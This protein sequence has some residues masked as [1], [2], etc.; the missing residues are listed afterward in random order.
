M[1]EEHAKNYLYRICGCKPDYLFAEKVVEIIK[2]L[3]STIEE[4]DKQNELLAKHFL[5]LQKDK[6]MLT[7]KVAELEKQIAELK[8]EKGCETCTKF[9]EVKLTKAKE[10]IRE[11]IKTVGYLN[12]DE[13]GKVDIPIVHKAEAFINKE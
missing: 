1:T 13:Y 10:I 6:G 9:D 12:D 8:T 11:L 5:E 3:E 4:K 7:D 2:N